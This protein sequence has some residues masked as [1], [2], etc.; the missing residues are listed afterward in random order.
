MTLS[1]FII[2]CKQG[3]LRSSHTCSNEPAQRCRMSHITAAVWPSSA[4]LPAIVLCHQPL[5]PVSSLWNALLPASP[6]LSPLPD[7]CPVFFSLPVFP[8]LAVCSPSAPCPWVPG[9]LCFSV[10][11]LDCEGQRSTCPVYLPLGL[12]QNVGP[13]YFLVT[14]G[15][16]K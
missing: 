12:G 2:N 1:L 11:P 15:K 3:G 9:A 16:D 10:P 14:Y 8:S 6:P 4:P 13:S 7:E 5:R